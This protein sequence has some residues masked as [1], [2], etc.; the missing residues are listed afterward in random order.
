MTILKEVLIGLQPLLFVV[1]IVRAMTEAAG[2]LILPLGGIAFIGL[3]L[4][5]WL[6]FKP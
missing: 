3:V 6:R 4:W 2:P 5:L 1:L